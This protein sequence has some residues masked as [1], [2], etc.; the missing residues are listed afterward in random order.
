MLGGLWQ[1]RVVDGPSRTRSHLTINSWFPC[2]DN[3]RTVFISQADS[4]SH[5]REIRKLWKC[6]RVFCRFPSDWTIPYWTTHISLRLHDDREKRRNVWKAAVHFWAFACSQLNLRPTI[7]E[8]I[9]TFYAVDSCSDESAALN[10]VQCCVSTCQMGWNRAQILRS[11]VNM[12]F[13]YSNPPLLLSSYQ[14]FP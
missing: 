13:F 4:W 7:H 2:T 9:E 11:I 8:H 12:I 10:S 3:F 14:L 5:Q 6:A 1:E